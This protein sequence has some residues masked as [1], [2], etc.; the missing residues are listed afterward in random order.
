METSLMALF[1]D[2]RGEEEFTALYEYSRAKLQ[3]HVA[4]QLAGSRG[5]LDPREVCQDVFVNVYRYS[6]GFRDEQPRSFRVW[7]CT[8][9]RNAIRRRYARSGGLSFQ[10][11]PEGISE[12]ADPRRGPVRQL[13]LEE[14]RK[15]I[16][17]AWTILLVQYRAAYELLS[18]RDRLALHLIEVEGLTYLEGCERLGVGMSNMKMIMFRARRRLRLHIARAMAHLTESDRLAG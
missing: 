3:L 1:R 8:I 4:H 10:D 7:S 2:A 6:S 11:L 5:H 12:P 14:D 18:E 9:A 17:N 15:R 16:A 13:E